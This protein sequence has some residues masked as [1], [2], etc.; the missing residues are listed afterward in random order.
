MII[1]PPFL[2][3]RG[4]TQS[5]DAWL[6]AAMPTPASRLTDTHAA[7]GSF[8]L[9]HN[10]A[11]H[12]GVHIQAPVGDDGSLP[13]RAVADGTVVFVHPPTVP[14]TNVDD[15][16]NY[17]PFDPAGA[18]KTAA[19]TDN[20]CVIIEHTTT[21]GATDTAET[22]VVFYSLTMHLSVL[23]KIIPAGQTVRREL[24]VGDAIWRKDEVGSPGQIYGHAGQIHFEICCDAVNLQSLIGRAPNW[25]G[26]A[27][28]PAALPE[29]T[30]DGRI[31]AIFGSLYFYLPDDTPTDAGATMPT[32]HL[33][34]ADGAAGTTLNASLW[35]KMTYERG[36]C[37]FESFDERGAPIHAL[38]AQADAEYD[39]Y[40]EATDRHG[41]LP[42]ASRR[43]SS[44]SGW[45]ELLRFGR[46][47]GRGAADADKDPLPIDAAHWR[48]I[49]G[50]D[51]A[52]VWADLN[53]TGSFKFSDAD[54]LPVMGWNCIDDD[55]TPDDQ[56]CDSPHLKELIRDPDADNAQGMEPDQLA[57]RLGHPD[58]RARLRR[59]ICK[60]PSEWDQQTTGERYGFAEDLLQEITQ[61]TEAWTRLHTHL[62]A[63]S[64]T[65]LPADYLAADWRVHPR[66]FVGE[67]RKCLWLSEHELIQFVPTKAVRG[68][69]AGLRGPF[70]Y[71]RIGRTGGNLI[72]TH[73]DALNRTWR[74]Y[75]VTTRARLAA[76]VGNSVQETSWWSTT[77]EGDGANLRYAPWFGR[78]F[79]QLTNPDGQFSASSNYGKYFLFRGRHVAGATPAQIAAWR[80]NV[81]TVEF[82]AADSGGAYWA[83]NRANEEAETVGP[84]SRRTITIAPK[85]QLL[86]G[87]SLTIYEN[88]PFRRVA[89]LINMPAAIGSA[90][91]QLNGLV[92]RYSGY[93]AAQV[94]LFD[95]PGFP[96]VSGGLAYLPEE[97]T[98]RRPR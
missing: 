6:D 24:Q 22:Q 41:A 60:F 74:K 53:A 69:G 10:L 30:A 48:R 66:E 17:N 54:F 78:G 45:Y 13:A 39:L 47:I 62:Q 70:F 89:C 7:E 91:P 92:D 84:N 3:A 93:A 94:A 72:R 73:H 27:V 11:W 79:L 95:A 90:N 56:R 49:A 77:Q 20:G 98:A 61:D 21:I 96:D 82:D 33:R 29:P 1:S 64:F 50:P 37:T 65:G 38:A 8:P 5:E 58:V 16:Q 18:A 32:R 28:A 15:P 81:G 31:D 42:E 9:S 80:D 44:P 25:V 97:F 87:Q 68:K 59:A 26:P 71:E 88:V 55:T 57:S 51:G 63:I 85:S 19:W 14:N 35:V 23:G 83:W 34:R 12:N 4:A 86:P 2:P 40:Q 67:M 52:A 43:T 46:N 36:A 75:C 76:F